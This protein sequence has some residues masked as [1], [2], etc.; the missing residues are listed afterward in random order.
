[1]FTIDIDASD[2]QRLTSMANSLERAAQEASEKELQWLTNE[3]VVAEKAAIK[4]DISYTGELENSV[5]ADVNKALLEAA[6]GPRLAN[7]NKIW[8]IYS[9]APAP[10]W[11]SL[12]ILKR[13]AADKLQNE[14]LGSYLQMAIAGYIPGRTEG[15]SEWQRIQRGDPG[16]PFDEITLKSSLIDIAGQ[17]AADKIG[18]SIVSFAYI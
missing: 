7:E 17:V 13:W 6:V 16:Y 5:T 10:R 4:R 1:M 14:N 8:A 3:V 18:Q 15:T 12:G 2:I 11:I 9:G